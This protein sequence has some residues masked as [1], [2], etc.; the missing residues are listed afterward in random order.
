MSHKYTFGFWM[1]TKQIL[2]IYLGSH[3]T[4]HYSYYEDTKNN[5]KST[6]TAQSAVDSQICVF[7]FSL[8]FVGLPNCQS[9]LLLGW[10][11]I[12]NHPLSPSFSMSLSLSPP[13]HRKLISTHKHERTPPLWGLICRR[14]FS[15]VGFSC[16]LRCRD[17]TRINS[18]TVQWGKHKGV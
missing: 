11:H 14:S 17:V 8:S 16:S 4:E 13:S 10:F 12:N 1:K 15:L 6:T 18:I 9:S 3:S 7:G 5:S 2:L